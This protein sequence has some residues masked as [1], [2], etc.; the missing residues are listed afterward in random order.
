MIQL[1]LIFVCM[2]IREQ[3]KTKLDEFTALCVDHNVKS[4]YAFGSSVTNRFDPDK[5]D[6]DLLVEIEEYD[7]VSRGEK[8]I[9]LWDK[10]EYFF[11]T[12]VDLLTNASIKNSILRK[13]IDETKILIYEGKN[14][15]VLV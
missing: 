9:D 4:L 8:L 1:M 2:R 14:H 6:I 13:N 7:P 5:S 11:N 15:K 3:I 10:L 12:K